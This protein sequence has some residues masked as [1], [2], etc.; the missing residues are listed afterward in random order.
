MTALG[1]KLKSRGH[2][3]V[4]IGVPDTESAVRTANL[5]FV[6]FCERESLSLAEKT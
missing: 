4:F 3:V 2:V 6:P 1:R 5:N